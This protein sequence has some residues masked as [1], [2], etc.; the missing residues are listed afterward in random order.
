MMSGA[1]VTTVNSSGADFVNPSC[2]LMPV[3]EGN[4]IPSGRMA[5]RMT[6]HRDIVRIVIVGNRS[7]DR[8]SGLVRPR[9]EQTIV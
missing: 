2:S 6:G 1:L 9:A 3:Q 4:A 7:L 5:R 8:D